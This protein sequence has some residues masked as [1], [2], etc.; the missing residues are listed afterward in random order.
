MLR[1]LLR[2]G[3]EGILFS[4]DQPFHRQSGSSGSFT[5]FQVEMIMH[6]KRI[7]HPGGPRGEA[8]LH[9]PPSMHSWD[10][11]PSE[12]CPIRLEK[13]CRKP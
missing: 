2:R 3:G 10:F 12:E 11:K 13:T 6:I 8:R 7:T 1:K 9:A 5:L 4:S